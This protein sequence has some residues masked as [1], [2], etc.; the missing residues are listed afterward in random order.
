[1][2]THIFAGNLLIIMSA[3]SPEMQKKGITH[4]SYFDGK[5]QSLGFPNGDSDATAGV[6]SPGVHDFGTASR[7]E[8]IKVVHGSL[9]HIPTGVKF[10]EG[11]TLTVEPGGKIQISC[12]QFTAYVCYYG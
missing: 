4:N 9:T 10:D 2:Q 7:R 6:F 1:M 3:K 8:R 11:Q 5:V 12:D